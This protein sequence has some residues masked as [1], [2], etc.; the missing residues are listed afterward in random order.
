MVGYGYWFAGGGTDNYGVFVFILDKYRR[1]GYGRQLFRHIEKDL[2]ERSAKTLFLE[3]EHTEAARDFMMAEGFSASAA[4]IMICHTVQIP[5]D[6]TYI[7]QARKEDFHDVMH[8]WTSS[9][10]RM[11]KSLGH[12]FTEEDIEEE[13]DDAGIENYLQSLPDRYVLETD[14]GII[15]EGE[16]SEN[17]IG[18]V[19]VRIGDQ[20]KGYGTS[21]TAYLTQ[22]IFSR[23]Y[24]E[25][26]FYRRMSKTMNS[27]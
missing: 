14:N 22:E 19:A 17:H 1:R 9:Y 6:P 7:R 24:S 21:L 10:R 13:A 5:V 15:A 27:F 8:L 26:V 12:P 4:D 20:N 11:L 2:L 18:G 3:C 25:A 23:G 16:I